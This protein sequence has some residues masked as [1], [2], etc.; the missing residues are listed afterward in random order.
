MHVSLKSPQQH[1]RSRYDQSLEHLCTAEMTEETVRLRK[2]IEQNRLVHSLLHQPC[3]ASDIEEKAQLFDSLLDFRAQVIIVDGLQH[4]WNPEAIES[5]EA[6]ATRLQCM[7]WISTETNPIVSDHSIE[8]VEQDT[9]TL[10]HNRQTIAVQPQTLLC[11]HT[12]NHLS[13]S[14]VTL[15]SGGTVGA[16][17]YFGE[18]AE[19]VGMR[20]INFTFEGHEQKRTKGSNI[21]NEKELAVG[22]TSLS[23]VSN[24]LNRNWKRTEKLQKV[25]Q[26][27]WHIVSHAD[28]VFVVGT[29]QLDGTVHGGTGWSVEL[30]KRWHKQTWVFDQTQGS[31]FHWNGQQWEEQTPSI[32]SKNIAGCG[33]RFLN[34]Q[35][36][37]AIRSLFERSFS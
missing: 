34:H 24:V 10:H 7:I 22:A 21:L 2:S 25:V 15:F 28:Q 32:T 29:I 8:I 4:E 31:W 27:L 17:A 1:V 9:L 14:N 23:Y 11:V 36:K 33:T 12:T 18:M 37:K 35:G 16:E 13:A 19:A 6:I 5:W 26:V 20:E 30:A 3:Q